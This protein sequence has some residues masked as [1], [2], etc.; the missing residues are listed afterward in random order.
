MNKTIIVKVGTESLAHFHTS[1]KVEK[2]I[3]DIARLIQEQIFVVL[4]SSGA[5]GCG[6]EMLPQ[7][8]N[9][10]ILAS[11]GQPI[12]MARYAEKFRQHGIV[13][14]Q[15]LPTHATLEEIPSHRAQFTSTVKSIM[16]AWILPII[17]E[18]DSLSTAEMRE[19][20]QWADND[21]NALLIARILGATD[22]I[23]L[24]NTNGVYRDKNDESTRIH[25]LKADTITDEWI[26]HVCWEKS[27]S[28]TGGM[29]S[30]LK[31][32]KAFSESGVTHICNG[33]HSGTYEHAQ[34]SNI[35]GGTRI[36]L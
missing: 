29:Q 31:I 9:K 26:H 23:L 28:W 15:I 11:V 16:H 10:Q 30:K 24:T 33:I 3:A 35:Q 1:E 19:L 20:G 8:T 5:V 21:K 36:I 14:A 34:G 4:V 12:L 32:G 6:R 7:E 17:N 18:N 22:I 2:M 13:T 25:T 27:T